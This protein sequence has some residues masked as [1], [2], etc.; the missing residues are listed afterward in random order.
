M[1]FFSARLKRLR[2]DRLNDP[3]SNSEMRHRKR[4]TSIFVSIIR[5]LALFSLYFAAF[6][7]FLTRLIYVINKKSQLNQLN[8]NKILKYKIFKLLISPLK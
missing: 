3:P 5:S 1:L 2:F 4:P 6:A 7:Y 8:R